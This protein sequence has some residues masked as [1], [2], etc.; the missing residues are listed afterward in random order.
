[1]QQVAQQV[2]FNN[3]ISSLLSM[4]DHFPFRVAV[5]N[6]HQKF[7]IDSCQSRSFEIFNRYL[8]GD[9]VGVYHEEIKNMV[10]NYGPRRAIFN[11]MVKLNDISSEMLA[12]EYPPGVKRQELDNWIDGKAGYN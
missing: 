7:N 9:S 3:S 11:F 2:G 8:Q 12:E 5:I 6:V 4:Q 10:A 1:M